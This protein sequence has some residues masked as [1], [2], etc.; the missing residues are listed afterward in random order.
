MS[1]SSLSLAWDLPGFGLSPST[2][3]MVRAIA[4]IARVLRST[5]STSPGLSSTAASAAMH[6]SVIA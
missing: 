4:P 6:S 5:E 1:L 3:F 2:S